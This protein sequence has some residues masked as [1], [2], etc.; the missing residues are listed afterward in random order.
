[1]NPCDPVNRCKSDCGTWPLVTLGVLPGWKIKMPH[2]L[3]RSL[4]ACCMSSSVSSEHRLG[5]PSML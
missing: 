3:G 1:M 2:P 5:Q 4:C